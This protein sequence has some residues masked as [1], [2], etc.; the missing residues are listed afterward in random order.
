M[1]G[2]KT[3]E[4][5]T[6]EDRHREEVSA[7]K[8]KLQWFAENQELL[9]RDAGR[10][11]AATG[12]IHQLKEQVRLSCHNMCVYSFSQ[13]LSFIFIIIYTKSIMFFSLDTSTHSIS[14]FP[15]LHTIICS[16]PWVYKSV[17]ILLHNY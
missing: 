1:S 11:K 5:R 14:V 16:F 2:D 8:K 13:C 4:M 6:L 12:E 3:L 7:L 17:I 10:L 9:D 15:F